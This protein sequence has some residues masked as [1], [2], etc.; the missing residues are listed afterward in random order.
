VFPNALLLAVLGLEFR[1]ACFLGRHSTAC[2]I[3][4]A[5][6]LVLQVSRTATGINLTASH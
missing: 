2:A 4:P 1:A 3:P 6:V 5:L